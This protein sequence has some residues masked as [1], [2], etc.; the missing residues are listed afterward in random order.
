MTI[1]ADNDNDK[2]NDYNNRQ[3]LKY[4]S[5]ATSSIIRQLQPMIQVKG[6]CV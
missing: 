1:K 5:I 6:A 2:N 4:E 3:K